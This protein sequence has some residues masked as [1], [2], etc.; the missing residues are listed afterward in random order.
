MTLSTTKP[1][2]IRYVPLTDVAA[3]YGL[4]AWTIRERARRGELPCLKH[5]GAKQIL[6]REDWLDAWDSG[7]E[8]MRELTRRERIILRLESR[9]DARYE[10]ETWTGQL[11]RKSALRGPGARDHFGV[12]GD[13]VHDEAGC[14]AVVFEWQLG[15][16]QDA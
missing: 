9:A 13:S 1:M 16:D 15:D 2:K 10:P 6:F 3:R 7:V 8:L 5:P 11:V 4:S 12:G 14:R